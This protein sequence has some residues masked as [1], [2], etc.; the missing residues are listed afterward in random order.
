M[1]EIKDN[2][3]IYKERLKRDRE[4]FEVKERPFS[5]DLAAAAAASSL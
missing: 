3:Q 4:M 1:V 5:S 2:L